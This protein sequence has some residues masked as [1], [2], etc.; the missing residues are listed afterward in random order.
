MATLIFGPWWICGPFPEDPTQL[1]A[2]EQDG[3]KPDARY[4]GLGGS[5]TW[6]LAP[7]QWRGEEVKDLRAFFARGKRQVEY[8]SAY[9]QIVITASDNCWAR[10]RLKFDDAGKVL[11][12]GD[13]R[14]ENLRYD[15]IGREDGVEV[16]TPLR[17]GENSI[18]LRVIQAAGDW[19]FL[20]SAEAISVPNIQVPANELKE[21]RERARE[22]DEAVAAASEAARLA[23]KLLADLNSTQAEI[24]RLEAEVVARYTV[25]EVNQI[26]VK[27]C[28]GFGHEWEDEAAEY[29]NKVL[30]KPS[31]APTAEPNGDVLQL[32]EAGQPAGQPK[33]DLTKAIEELTI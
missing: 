32:G 4:E 8:A 31:L 23:E 1:F 25:D 20:F 19:A 7:A 29:I 13:Q 15:W 33:K 28:K 21:L 10:L 24:E 30:E 18:L 26:L 2:P 14:G 5:V 6:Q 9:A 27:V 3:F 16:E 12:N 11:V 17:K 22:R